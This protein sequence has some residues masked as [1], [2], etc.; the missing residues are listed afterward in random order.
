MGGAA[1]LTAVARL[2]K[3]PPMLGMSL[4]QMRTMK[5]A[6]VIDGSKVERELG[7]RYTP[8][9]QAVKE[10]IESYRS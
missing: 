3:K 5:N 2:T 4:D 10:A 6:P 1:F 7:I 9:R 8:V